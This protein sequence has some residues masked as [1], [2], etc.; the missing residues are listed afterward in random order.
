MSKT[1]RLSFRVKPLGVVSN[2]GYANILH[3]GNKQNPFLVG[4]WFL[5]G[6]TKLHTCNTIN[7]RTPCYNIQTPILLQK[8]SNI[9]IQQIQIGNQY[10][11]QF[12][13]NGKKEYDIVNTQ[14]QPFQDV[15]FYAAHPSLWVPANG[16]ISDFK[17]N[18]NYGR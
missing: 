5:R 10:Q 12:F 16:I 18:D 13:V 11:F 17:I 3:A 15:T 14:P 7:G 8:F 6:T 1:W 4:V 2:Y 9:T